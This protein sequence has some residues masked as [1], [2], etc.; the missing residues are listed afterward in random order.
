MAGANLE[1]SIFFRLFQRPDIS[2]K[3]DEALT[4]RLRYSSHINGELIKIYYGLDGYWTKRRQNRKSVEGEKQTDLERIICSAKTLFADDPF[5]W[6]ANKSANKSVADTIFNST[7]G[8]R[9]PNAPYGFNEYDHIHNIVI[10]SAYNPD[11]AHYNFLKWRGVSPE[12]VRT[13][14]AFNSAYQAALRT[15]IR[16]SAPNPKKIYVPDQDTA[17]YLENLFPGCVLE[18]IDLGIQLSKDK[19]PGRTKKHSSNSERQK[20]HRERK[21]EE[22]IAALFNLR[23][24][25]ENLRHISN[26]CERR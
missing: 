16:S 5:L 21:K 14:I 23:S 18:R 20:K 2:F 13:A 26:Q 10:L 4:G 8:I 7:Q 17:L 12:E 15:S 11:P 3:Q 22:Q 1:N 9:L 25:E 24:L 19:K 6:I